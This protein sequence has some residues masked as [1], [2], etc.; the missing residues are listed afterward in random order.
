[1]ER[2][3][4]ELTYGT[5]VKKLSVDKRRL[6]GP[7]V[8]PLPFPASDRSPIEVL[9]EKLAAPVGR[10]RLR[11]M[12]ADKVVAIVISDEFRAGLQPQIAEVL[13]KEAA[14]GN[15]AEIR[16]FFATGTHDPAIYCRNLAPMVREVGD[17]L[18]CPVTLIEHDCDKSEFVDLGQTS[19]GT[20][21]MVEKPWMEADV[22][23]YGHESK[24]HYMAGYSTVDK[25]VIPG[26]SARRTVEDNHKLSLQAGSGPGRN[27]WHD[28]AERRNN[29]FSVDSK[30]ARAITESYWMSPSG[31]LVKKQVES[32]GLD[33][34]S[35]GNDIY[36]AQ[37]GDP[38]PMMRE[39]TRQADE[40]AL[41]Q[42]EKTRYVVISPG[43]P[44]ACQ[45]LYG[46]QNC[47]DMALLGAIQQGGEAL[48]IA[49]CD[50]R[51]DLPSDV[52]G[53]APDG[54]SKK[55]FWDNLLKLK[56]W[57]LEKCFEHIRDNFQLYM[58]KTY[59]VLKNFKGDELKIYIHCELPDE[60]LLEGGFFPAPDIDAWIKEREDLDDGKIR[61]IDDGNK[62]CIVGK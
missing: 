56:E 4:F 40:V 50:G 62:L 24:H 35:S 38:G 2:E 60:T 19:L 6:A 29:P 48:V 18:D 45:A 39:M 31:A 28:V 41:V 43:G 47:F 9:N 22:R 37:A 12:V 26:I 15:P 42:L 36:W 32:F 27:P 52:S 8:A 11:E 53:L 61:V 59:R 21:L 17:S 57:P 16:V 10:P 5:S 13:M 49:P 58:W 51:P 34:I 7:L 55:L 30:E 25:Q 1:M 14:A 23:V 33:M 3:H 54:K 20:H 46:V 44:P